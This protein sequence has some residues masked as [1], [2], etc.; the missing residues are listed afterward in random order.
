MYI[1]T[2]VPRRLGTVLGAVR[3]GRVRVSAPVSSFAL[4]TSEN[5]E[6]LSSSSAEPPTQ[7]NDLSLRFD[8]IPRQLPQVG[9]NVRQ[10]CVYIDQSLSNMTRTET[11]PLQ[12]LKCRCQSVLYLRGHTKRKHASRKEAPK[13]HPKAV[14]L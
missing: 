5:L 3:V 6:L 12:R 10:W 9:S 13:P 2:Q 7:L 1:G 8:L 14:V 4:G 11:S